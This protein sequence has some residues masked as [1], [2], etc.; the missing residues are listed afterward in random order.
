MKLRSK[1]LFFVTGCIAAFCALVM[2][3][4]V[5]WAAR[6]QAQNSADAGALAGAIALAFDDPTD[7]SDTGAAKLS[8]HA[9]AIANKV[10]GDAPDNNITT[11]VTFPVCPD[12]SGSPCV[13][14]DVFR[15]SARS[16]PLPTFFA[17]LLSI[18]RSELQLLRPASI[19]G[20]QPAM[21]GRVKTP[22]RVPRLR[23]KAHTS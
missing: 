11:D 23:A 12:G 14:V 15:T 2:D 10:F 7:F 22:Y 1:I 21:A 5:F 18:T 3:Y 17:R 20:Y 16:N 8:A 13:K 19:S 6:R 9:A 4:G